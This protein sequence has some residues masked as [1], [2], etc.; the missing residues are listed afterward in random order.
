MKSNIKHI[1]SQRSARQLLK[2]VDEI[3]VTTDTANTILK[4]I[5]DISSKTDLL[6]LNA[7]IEAARAGTAGR[8][9]AVVA[10]DVSKLSEK[11]LHSLHEV[12]Q[13]IKEIQHKV[14]TLKAN[15]EKV[16]REEEQLSEAA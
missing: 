8:G 6:A 3:Q 4:T 12:S 15:L 7:A 16:D 10:D 14:S 13:V 9:F 5:A 2:M 1:P 11:T